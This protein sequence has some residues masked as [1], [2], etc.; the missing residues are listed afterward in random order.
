MLNI[1]FLEIFV[2]SCFNFKFLKKMSVFIYYLFFVLLWFVYW[3]NILFIKVI[4]YLIFGEAWDISVSWEVRDDKVFNEY[5][6]FLRLIVYRICVCLLVVFVIV[7]LVWVK[8][9]LLLMVWVDK[10]F[11]YFVEV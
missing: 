2:F 10:I 6:D 1:F 5:I 9:G 3:V 4:S 7:V 8:K 11:Y